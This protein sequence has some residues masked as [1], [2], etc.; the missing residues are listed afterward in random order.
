MRAYQAKALGDEIAPLLATI[1]VPASV[2]A[3]GFLAGEFLRQA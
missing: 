1:I 3:I 2:L